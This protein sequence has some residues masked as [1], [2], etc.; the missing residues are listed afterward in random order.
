MVPSLLACQVFSF[1]PDQREGYK[2]I[3]IFTTPTTL[4]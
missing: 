1:R 3:D 4:L 2:E